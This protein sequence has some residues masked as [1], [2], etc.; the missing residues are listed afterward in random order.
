MCGDFADYRRDLEAIRDQVLEPY[1]PEPHF[2]LAHSMG[3]AIALPSAR[4]RGW[5][6][7]ARLVADERR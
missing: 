6:P 4:V 5:L 2:A 7:F 3:G 1:M